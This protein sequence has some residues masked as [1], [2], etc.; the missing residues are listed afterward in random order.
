MREA[1]AELEEA[2]RNLEIEKDTSASAKAKAELTLELAKLAHQ[3]WELGE[4]PQKVRDL[5][6]ALEHEPE[7][8]D[9][10]RSLAATL[11]KLGKESEAKAQLRRYLELAPEAADRDKVLEQLGEGG[12]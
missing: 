10:T 1:E 8:A 6:L 5:N 4:H 9:A 11:E 2:R 7:R 12:L 3:Q